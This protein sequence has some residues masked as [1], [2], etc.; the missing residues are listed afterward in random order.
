MDPDSR[1]PLA[2]F[3]HRL[4]L[5][6][7][8]TGEEQEAVLALGGETEQFRSHE[9]IVSPGERVEHACL[10][11]RGLA[12]RF[13]QMLDGERQVTSFYIADDMCDLHSVV[14]PR[15]SWSI[16]AMSRVTALRVPHSQLRELCIRYPGLALAF[17][18]DGTVDASIFAKWV[19][20]LGRKNA[21]ARIGHIFCEMG[22]RSEAARLGSR[23]SYE[24][25]LT[26]NQL[27]DAA[28]LTPVHVNRTLQELKR[29]GLLRFDSGRVDIPDWDALAAIAE[30]GPSYLLLDGP[31][32]RVFPRALQRAGE[33]PAVG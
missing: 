22:V 3:L 27:A 13:D 2:R 23:T 12:G 33:P 21:R 19:G 26:Q 16:T 18:R 32:Q 28:G 4:R 11:A 9:D 8:L 7:V 14:A 20:N 10:V 1:T 29:G 5:R 25:P 15:A 31:P 17:W 30:F 6:S 24:L